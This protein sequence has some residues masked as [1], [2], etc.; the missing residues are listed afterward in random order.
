MSDKTD[1]KPI[2]LSR[3]LPEVVDGPRLQLRIW[4]PDYAD[5][6]AAAVANSMEEL[7]PWMP[8]VAH[9][10]LSI[11]DRRA[12]MVERR[13]EWSEGGDGYYLALLD[14]QVVGSCGLHT[15]R[16]PGILEVGYWIDSSHTGRGLATEVAI[17]L[18]GVALGH[19]DI[20]TVELI[21]ARPNGASARVAAKAG[22]VFAGQG[23][24]L[25]GAPGGDGVG[26]TWRYMTLPGF[27]IRAETVADHGA[28]DDVVGT[29]F[30]SGPG[31]DH[32]V[33]VK[34]VHDI[35]HS[36]QSEP[37]MALVA[38][39]DDNRTP[40]RRRLVG[41][42]M[43]SGCTLRHDDGRETPIKMLSPLAVV[44]DKQRHGIG[45]AL[46][47]A[48]VDRAAEAGEPL[49][50]LEGDPA[51]YNRFGFTPAMDHG[52]TLPVPDWAPAE[53]AQVLWIGQPDSALTGTVVYPAA[54]DGLE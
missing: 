42:V 41:H 16:G 38:E 25:T 2:R 21:H 53:A 35:R 47:K 13:A 39:I 19:P 30:G 20:S 17:T 54:F 3:P 11:D 27:T 51:Y 26:W 46:V 10:P 5:G 1:E 43:I 31:S 45:G 36:P 40:G 14:D 15:R 12:R 37:G 48:A 7:R 32:P 29:A 6:L 4:H 33:E 49:V 22:F 8:W 34:L 50:I 23:P 44:P 9:E 28:I 18:A 24:D 52:I